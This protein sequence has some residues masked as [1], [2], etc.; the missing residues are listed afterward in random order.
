MNDL[1]SLLDNKINNSIKEDNIQIDTVQSNVIQK[2][3]VCY[4]YKKIQYET[5]AHNRHK[6]DRSKPLNC[7]LITDME[8]FMNSQNNVNVPYNKLDKFRKNKLIDDY[9]KEYAKLNNLTNEEAFKII[10]L[11]IISKKKIIY[12]IENKKI[13]KIG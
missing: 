5:M 12:D 7:E 6:K 10:N 1:I 3:D 2:E 8:V 9:I 11:A 4:E 13:T